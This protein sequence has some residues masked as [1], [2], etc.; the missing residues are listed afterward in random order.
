MWLPSDTVQPR[1]PPRPRCSPRRRWR[2]AGG[3]APAGRPE[4][5]RRRSTFSGGGLLGLAC[6]AKPSAVSVTV[7]RGE[8]A[9]R[10]QQ[11]RPPARRC[12]L[13]GATGGEIG[14]R[15]RRRRAVPPRPGR[16]GAQARL[17]ARPTSRLR[18]G[19]GR[20]R[21]TRGRARAVPAGTGPARG[22]R[23]APSGTDT[24]ARRH[25][26]RWHDRP[27]RRATRTRASV[28][29]GG[30]TAS[31]DPRRPAP[32]RRPGDRPATATA[33]VDGD[34]RRRPSRRD[35][36]RSAGAAAEPL[37][38]VDPVATSGPTG[39]LALIA[40]VC[41]VGVIAGQFGLLSL[42]VQHGLATRK[43]QYHIGSAGRLSS[44]LVGVVVPPQVPPKDADG[45]PRGSR[46][47]GRDD[48]RPVPPR[49]DR[50][51]VRPPAR[52]V[53]AGATP[54]SWSGCPG[55]LGCRGN[56]ARPPATEGPWP[57]SP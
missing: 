23:S 33:T 3:A 26:D 30:A 4:P 12:V 36:W 45:A 18:A 6:G 37:A 38:S 35:S 1:R 39:L 56:D 43:I 2:S 9:A 48:G 49:H 53:V 40:T 44:N 14:H 11:H 16:A 42:N 24:S 17:R 7:P 21:A 10:R 47:S 22:R 31:A 20:R 29:T 25:A 32:S 57:L 52:P 27:D 51:T 50:H 13:D 55:H 34:R 8:H 54:V 41:V 19:R 15:A 5:A 28:P 46:L